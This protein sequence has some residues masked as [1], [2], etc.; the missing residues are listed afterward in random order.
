MQK[1][2]IIR[3]FFNRPDKTIIIKRELSQEQAREHCNNPETSSTTCKL[4][5]Y[6]H[7]IPWFDGWNKE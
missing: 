2:K 6:S 1:Y 4:N 5:P 3:F 7:G